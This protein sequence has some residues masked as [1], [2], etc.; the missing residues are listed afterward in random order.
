[1]G[2]REEGRGDQDEE[3]QGGGPHCQ[4]IF[5]RVVTLSGDRNHRTALSLAGCY[6]RAIAEAVSSS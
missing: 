3:E 6:K 4:N 5:G 1:V 2:H